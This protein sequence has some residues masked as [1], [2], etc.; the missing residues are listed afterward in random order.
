L[1][2]QVKRE[3]ERN[4][5]RKIEEWSEKGNEREKT[6]AGIAVGVAAAGRESECV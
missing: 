3:K 4:E 5:Q 1:L 6:T 2:G